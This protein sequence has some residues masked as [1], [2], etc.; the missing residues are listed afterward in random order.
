VI[1]PLADEFDV[2]DIALAAVSLAERRAG[3]DGEEEPEIAPASFIERDKPGKGRPAPRSQVG[4]KPP[5]RQRGHGGPWARLVV[6]G[7][8]RM[9]LRPGDLVGAITGEAG[10]PGSA[11]GAIVISD[12]DASVEVPEAMADAVVRALEAGTI[13]GRHVPVRRERRR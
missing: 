3:S 9:G 6:A 8:R 7:G 12:D 13:R 10:I 2:V 1:E 11:I 5:P 4:R